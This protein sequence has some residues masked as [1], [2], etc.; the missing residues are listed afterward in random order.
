MAEFTAADISG[1]PG[2]WIPVEVD[3]KL[4]KAAAN[5]SLLKLNSDYSNQAYH[6]G[7]VNVDSRIYMP[8]M[9]TV[10]QLILSVG[11]TDCV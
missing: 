2:G 5:H 8:G 10:H 7:L 1:G 6:L 3:D 9:I 4:V 11:R